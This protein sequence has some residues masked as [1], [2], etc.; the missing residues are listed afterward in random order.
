MSQA[1][2]QSLSAVQSGVT[3]VC[4]VLAQVAGEVQ[5]LL[6][7]QP[8]QRPVTVS[9]TGVGAEQ[10]A[11]LVHGSTAQ[12]WVAVLQVSGKVQWVSLTHSKQVNLGTSQC[13]PLRQVL[14][15]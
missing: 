1:D 14:S 12:V 2:G 6:S 7:T 11:S 8:R 10:L 5:S 13:R 15:S 4:V 9:Q 3:Q